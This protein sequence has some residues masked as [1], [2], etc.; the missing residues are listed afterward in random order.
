MRE[1][2]PNPWIFVALTASSFVAF[3]FIVNHREKT[4]PAS[5][6]PRQLDH[7]LTPPVRTK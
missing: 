2:P 4:N 6:N 3:Y 1:K 7:P 5:R